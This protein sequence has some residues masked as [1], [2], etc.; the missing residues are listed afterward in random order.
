[1]NILYIEHYVGSPY[2][3]MEF[4]P[5]YLANEWVKQGHQVTILGASYSH[6]RQHQPEVELDFQEEDIE[7]INYVWLKTPEYG[8]SLAR[9]RN[10]ISFIWKLQRN[11]KRIANQYKPDLVIASSTYP[12]DNIPAYRIAKLVGAKYTYEIHDLWPLSPMLIGGYS[13]YHPF[14]AVM[15]Y[16]ED[17]AYKHA[18]KVISLLWNAEGHCIERGLQA[19]KFV[20]VPNGYNPE[21]WV[22]SKFDLIIPKEHQGIFDSLEGKIIVGFAGG[23][24]TSGN[25]ISLV[26]AAVKLK[27]R[28]DI[29]FVLV[30][31]GPELSSYNKVIEENQLTNI[32]ILPAVPKM[33]IPAINKHFNI[34][35]LGGTHSELHKYGTSYNKMTDYMLCS[36]P[37]VQSIDEPGSVVERVGCGIR[38]EAENVD[39]IAQA[40]VQ[41]VEM[42]VDERKEMGKKGKEYVEKFLPWNKLAKDFLAPFES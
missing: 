12:L 3:G 32:T 26:N 40:I 42:S 22:N 36:L 11:A 13:K 18:D 9:I 8:G 10:I 33:L 27:T 31:K 30:G 41:L 4:R 17:F 39:E 16:G 34:A 23:F 29:H 1:M 6:L 7:G 2:Y 15:Q 25:V 14:I 38:V 21:E 20:C 19:G 37:I 35:Y 5:Y 24:A 28:S